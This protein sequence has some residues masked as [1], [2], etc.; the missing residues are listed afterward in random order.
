MNEDSVTP[1][2]PRCCIGD[3]QSAS[4]NTLLHCLYTS[5]ARQSKIATHPIHSLPI[6][7]DPNAKQNHVEPVQQSTWSLRALSPTIAFLIVSFSLG[8]LVRNLSGFCDMDR[9][10]ECSWSLLRLLTG[11]VLL[12]G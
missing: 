12:L 4:L 3:L 2:M 8:E 7:D 1:G 10:I 11:F 6:M 5:K 9:R